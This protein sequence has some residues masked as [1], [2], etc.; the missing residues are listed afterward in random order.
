LAFKAENRW[1]DAGSFRRA[2]WRTRTRKYRFEAG[3]LTAA[4]VVAGGIAAAILFSDV[5][6]S[7]PIP[8]VAVLPFEAGRGADSSLAADLTLAT[9]TNLGHS[10]IEVADRDGVAAWWVEHE[11]N[12]DSVERLDLAGLGARNAVHGVVS[13]EGPDT[14]VALRVVDANGIVSDAGQEQ[15]RGSL[16]ETGRFI[17]LNAVTVVAPNRESEYR[18]SV[19]AGRDS[20]FNAYIEGL[21][22]FE[23]NE[24][25]TATELLNAAWRLYPEWGL[26]QWQLNNAHRWIGSGQPHD[27]I[28][29][30]DLRARHADELPEL[31]TMLIDAQLASGQAQRHALYQRAIEKYPHNGYAAFLY[32]DE[33]LMRG[34]H[35]G[36]PLDSAVA[37]LE[38]AIRKKPNF[39]PAHCQ[40]TWAYIRLGRQEEA[41][42][43]AF[44]C[45]E[46]SAGPG[47]TDVDQGPLMQLLIAARF[48]P[49]RADAV[50][51]GVLGNATMAETVSGYLRLGTMY[52]LAE[53]Q[54]GL[55][56]EFLML[57]PDTDDHS[58]A[59][60][61]QA[62]GLAL[63]GLGR[64]QEGLHDI[65]RAAELSGTVN[66]RLQAAEWRVLGRAMGLPGI[67]NEMVADGRAT[68]DSL[69]RDSA[70]RVSAAWALGVAASR[71][72]A[73]S[74]AAAWR[75]SLGLAEG[76]SVAQRLAAL[77]ESMIAGAAGDYDEALRTSAALL[78]YD[79]AG[80]GGDPF[81]RALLHIKRAEWLSMRDRTAEADASRRWYEQFEWTGGKYPTGEAQAAEIDWALATYARWLRGL[82]RGVATDE[83]CSILTRVLEL[84]A[85]ADA[86]YQPHKD[87]AMEFVERRCSS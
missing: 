31:V 70:S 37:Q 66:A 68:L 55:A 29:L 59:H 43:C 50:L 63:I 86:A 83:A 58:R 57:M 9:E 3:L 48:H 44:A 15:F 5:F 52:D 33:L 79:S 17:G 11:T 36:V 30:M 78:P 6:R 1:Q 19:M 84:W 41:E 77:L 7:K 65:G 85:Q 34:A 10:I 35:A 46:L 80:R 2:I 14:I 12:V 42:R 22:A 28:D 8:D 47:E 75:D 73:A 62:R 26:A 81:A 60:F 53:L 64:L 27:S 32:G 69:M 38:S 87:R 54:A 25:T 39:G 23:R 61:H 51:G 76:D 45:Q 4:G 24:F 74:A 56:S 71:G 40:L 16:S 82:A 20:A 18:G 72:G 13:V 21:Q 49:E 67:T